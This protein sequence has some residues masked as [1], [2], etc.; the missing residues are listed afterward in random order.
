MAKL[1]R[2]TV[3][4]SSV[5]V[6]TNDS[7]GNGQLLT[8]QSKPLIKISYTLTLFYG[9]FCVRLISVQLISLLQ[10]YRQLNLE[11]WVNSQAPGVDFHFQGLWGLFPAQGESH[12]KYRS[13]AWLENLAHFL[14][15]NAVPQ[16]CELF[17]K[18]TDPNSGKMSPKKVHSTRISSIH[19]M[20]YVADYVMTDIFHI[21]FIRER[22]RMPQIR[23]H[24]LEGLAPHWK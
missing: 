9:W 10:S 13:P 19:Q 21:D 24:W 6:K 23:H 14:S 16:F 18:A 11:A 5:T 12:S 2:Q 4:M 15:I 8:T 17:W 1:Q 22:E 7:D 20:P 3:G